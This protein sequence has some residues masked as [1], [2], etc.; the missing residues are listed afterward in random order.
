[1]KLND[2]TKNNPDYSPAHIA[3]EGVKFK[4]CL[5]GLRGLKR[6]KIEHELLDKRRVR[7]PRQIPLKRSASDNPCRHMALESKA[8]DNTVAI[9]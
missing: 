6:L 3:M 7:R 1:M 9:L 4:I 5:T 8:T 2:S